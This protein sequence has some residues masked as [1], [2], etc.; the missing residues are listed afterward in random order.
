MDKVYASVDLGGTKIACAFARADGA[1]LCQDQVLT[2][3]HQGPENVVTRIAD[4]IPQPWVWVFQDWL[5]GSRGK[6]CFYPTYQHSGVMF[7]FAICSN[8]K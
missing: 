4:L 5:T 6:R 2:Q 7:P 1:I 3:A 8:R